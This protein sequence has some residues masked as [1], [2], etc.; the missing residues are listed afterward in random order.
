MRG[1]PYGINLMQA[2][3]WG[4]VTWSLAAGSGTLNMQFDFI[5][6]RTIAQA[7]NAS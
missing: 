5:H 2:F 4:D 1:N 7:V 3:A 6:V